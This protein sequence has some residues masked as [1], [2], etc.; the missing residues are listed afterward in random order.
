MEVGGPATNG[1]IT[2]AHLGAKS[3]LLSVIGQH[4]FTSFIKDELHQYH[5]EVIDL[6]PAAIQL[7]TVSSIVTTHGGHRAV[8]TTRSSPTSSMNDAVF[9]THNNASHLLPVD[10]FTIATCS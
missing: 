8:I 6:S 7:P 3:H 10:L 9:L 1:A 5:V 2:F 4:P